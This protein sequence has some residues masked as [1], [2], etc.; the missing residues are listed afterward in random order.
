MI[1]YTAAGAVL[2]GCYG[3]AH[4]QIT[5]TIS[6]EYFTRLKFDQFRWANLGLPPRLF[7]GEVGFLATWWV[8]LIAAWFI[9]R[10]TVPAFPPRVALRH[11]VRGFAIVA[12][13]AVAAF[14][15]GYLLGVWCAFHTD[16]SG[17]QRSKRLGGLGIVDWQHFV[18]VA[19]IHAAGY[20]GGIL[21][22][23]VAV[24]HLRRLRR[25]QSLERAV[26]AENP[27]RPGR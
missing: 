9:A 2:A 25:R 18:V 16:L 11:T 4:D 6:E 5:Y 15:V 13:F 21:G 24:L 12:A 19:Y 26:T 1:G 10:V 8:G 7:V 23:I 27:A 17:W 22:L 14:V 20:L 3:I